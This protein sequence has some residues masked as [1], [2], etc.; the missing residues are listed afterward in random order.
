MHKICIK[1]AK[2]MQGLGTLK[3]MPRYANNMQ[4]IQKYAKYAIEDFICRVCTLGCPSL[5][6]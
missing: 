5:P 2:N 4:N 3:N 6:R 1:Y